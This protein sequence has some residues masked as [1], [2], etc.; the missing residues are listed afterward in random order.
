MFWPGGSPRGPCLV[1]TVPTRRE[2]EPAAPARACLGSCCRRHHRRHRCSRSIRCAPP[3]LGS[4]PLRQ[5]WPGSGSS[6][7]LSTQQAATTRL[8]S[9]Q[10]AFPTPRR[11]QHVLTLCDSGRAAWRAT[12]ALAG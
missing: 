7:M 12:S 2:A 8:A 3:L 1:L 10:Q 6:I 5:R 11:L 9:Q 4:P